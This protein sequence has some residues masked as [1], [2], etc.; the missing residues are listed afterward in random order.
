MPPRK[1]AKM[2]DA[3]KTALAKGRETARAVRDYLDWT[4]PHDAA[5]NVT[6]R[7]NG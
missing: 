2:T 5:G 1:Q 7:R 4:A 6:R 3:H